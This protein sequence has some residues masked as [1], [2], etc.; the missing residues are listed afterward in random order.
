[1]H[2]APVLAALALL[3]GGAAMLP[4]TGHA[5]TPPRLITAH[6]V[7]SV[8]CVP[9]AANTV[10][11]AVAM[12]M[13]VV[14]Y[15]GIGDWADH[16]EMK[17]RLESTAPGINIHSNWKKQKTPYLIQDKRHAYNMRVVTDNK[18]GSAGWRVH[19]KLIWHRPAPI[20]NVTKD[21]YLPFNASC[22]PQTGGGGITGASP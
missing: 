8:S 12:R 2:A 17:A 21:L 6:H 13:T 11:A 18:G 7:Q 14:N 3:A 5:K 20:R 4:A 19:V 16:M 1:M 15:S 10:R 9:G 22:A